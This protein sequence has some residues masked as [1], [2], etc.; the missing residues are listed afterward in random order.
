MTKPIK[1]G[2][3]ITELDVGGAERCLANL[4]IGL[5][6]SRFEPFVC[7]L[8]P[9]PQDQQAGLVGRLEAA[10]VPVHFLNA[11]SL[12]QL[13][14]TRRRLKQLLRTHQPEIVQTFLFHA[15]VLG[16]LAASSAGMPHIVMG[17]RVADPPRWRLA[18]ERCL[19]R[20]VDR[21]VCVSD[22]VAEFVR[23]RGG[24][25][26]SKLD[27]IPNG[28]D[29]SEYPASE[30]ADLA[31]FGIGDNR[32]VLICVGRLHRQKGLDWL[33]ECASELLG[34][35]PGHDLL[36][37]GDGPDR[38]AL[39]K[40]ANSLDV[41]N[42]IHFAGWR[43]D[44]PQLLAASDALLLTS[45]WEGMPNVLL[46]AMA[47]QLPVV[48]TRVEGVEQ[49]LGSLIA[50][51]GVAFGD[52]EALVKTIERIVSDPD[53]AARLGRLN[54]ARVEAEFA[55]PVII[56]RYEALYASLGE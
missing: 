10:A 12:W 53:H 54:R 24:F 42:R 43:A 44:V 45:R 30:P 17:I 33:L 19:S 6:R 36:F 16:T 11:Q 4:V 26:D 38:G 46:E 40:C 15:N 48:A 37:V 9:R 2:F 35:L 13:P 23:I 52:T 49:I 51:Q 21:I 47:S 29:L 39:V 18:V 1:L 56:S 55:L 3:V 28:I 8:A 27:V 41:A 14:S 32:R 22:S 5:D 7:S 34:R 25:T 50:D 20:R 31:Q